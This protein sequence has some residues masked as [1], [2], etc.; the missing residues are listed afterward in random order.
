[1]RQVRHFIDS[2]YIESASGAVFDKVAPATGAV[3][4]RVHEAGRDEV[5]RA[6][7]AARRA[8]KGEWGRLGVEQRCE[9]L[10]RVADGITARFDEFLAAECADTGKPYSLA[11]HIDIPRGAAN[12]KIFADTVRNCG[13]QIL[14]NGDPGR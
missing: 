4:A 10:Y 11:R 6:V 3:I 5:D 2:E 14:R 13:Q 8:L 1:M 12:F 9:R 7:A